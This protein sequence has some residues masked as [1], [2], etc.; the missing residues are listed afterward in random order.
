MS[1][2]P[3]DTRHFEQVL[4]RLNA[5][6]KHSRGTQDSPDEVAPTPPLVEPLTNVESTLNSEPALND[7][8]D[9]AIPLLTDIYVGQIDNLS[10]VE[11]PLLDNSAYVNKV[12]ETLMPQLRVV[13]ERALGEEMEKAKTTL[14]SRLHGEIAA[15][16][17]MHLPKQD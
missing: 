15:A 14:L 2:S 8:L 17:R 1:E 10:R 12:I 6:M 5:L 11:P 13:L 16:L 3:E 7:A 9:D 4:S